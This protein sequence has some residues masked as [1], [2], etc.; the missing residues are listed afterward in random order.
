M[1]TDIFRVCNL[2]YKKRKTHDPSMKKT[3]EVLR[4]FDQLYGTVWLDDISIGLSD[5][6]CV[7]SPAS[8]RELWEYSNNMDFSFI[9]H[10]K[11]ATQTSLD[12]FS[13]FA[14]VLC[15]DLNRHL[16]CS[17]FS[18]NYGVK[19]NTWYHYQQLQNIWVNYSETIDDYKVKEAIF[20]KRFSE[21]NSPSKI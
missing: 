11:F 1:D 14:R 20:R 10:I 13:R 3:S 9:R 2:E 7:Y 6:E 17:L 8:C 15:Y 19:T 12:I 5:S 16:F 18:T 21:D 4:Q